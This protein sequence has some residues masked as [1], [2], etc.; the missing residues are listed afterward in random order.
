VSP[1]VAR[2]SS[3]RHARALAAAAGAVAH[4]DA[5]RLDGAFHLA[6]SPPP[7]QLEEARAVSRRVVLAHLP[8]VIA[9]HLGA[10]VAT[11]ATLVVENLQQAGVYSL[12]RA[13]MPAGPAARLELAG[14]WPVPAL[15]GAS[16]MYRSGSWDKALAVDLE[17]VAGDAGLH[18]HP[19]TREFFA[20]WLTSAE[21]AM[22]AEVA[23]TAW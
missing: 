2:T 4:L 20:C 12:A 21:R 9:A 13:A 3:D 6:T 10:G 16:R 14:H 1:V 8:P 5:A 18:L 22:L 11:G 19:L 23:R 15:S 7:P 17:R